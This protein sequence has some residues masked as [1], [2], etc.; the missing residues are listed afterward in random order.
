[1]RILKWNIDVLKINLD[2]SRWWK[3]VLMMAQLNI[4]R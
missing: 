3:G 1:M 4:D 2:I